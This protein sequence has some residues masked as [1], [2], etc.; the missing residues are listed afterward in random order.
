MIGVGLDIEV[1][2]A[3][4]NLPRPVREYLLYLRELAKTDPDAAAT[5]IAALW[6][7]DYECVPVPLDEFVYGAEYLGFEG[8]RLWPRLFDDLC[9]IFDTSRKPIVEVV[10]G[11]ATG[12]GKTKLGG[13]IAAR[14]LYE[15]NCLRQP[16]LFHGIS[17]TTPIALMNLSVTAQQAERAFFAEFLALIDMSPYF[18]RYMTADVQQTG[19]R[20]YDRKQIHLVCGNSQ[21]LSAI[22]LAPVFAAID[23]ANF[24]MA[25]K[26]SSR[27]VAAGELDHARVLYNH[28]KRRIK[29]RFLRSP[30]F[31]GKV[32]LLSS[33]QF[34]DDFLE[35][36]IKE[37]EGQDDVIVLQ[38][39]QWET[40]PPESMISDMWDGKSFFRVLVGGQHTRSRILDDQDPAPAPED[41]ELIA[42]P[43]LYRHDFQT[44]L[45]GAVRDVAGKATITITPFIPNREAVLASSQKMPELQHPFSAWETTLQD[46]HHLV[47]EHLCEAVSRKRTTRDRWGR[48]TEHEELIWQPKRHP[49]SPRYVHIDLAV[50]GDACG[51]AMGYS[52]GW[53]WRK[54]A[55]PVTAPWLRRQVDEQGPEKPALEEMLEIVIEFQ[56]RIVAPR[57]GEI[58]FGQVRELVYQ[59]RDLG[60]YIAKVTYDQFQSVDSRQ[61]LGSKG[62]DAE[63]LSVD[64]NDGPYQ[65]LKSAIYEDR[66]SY[67]PH[68]TFM[69]EVVKL[70]RDMKTLKIDHTPKGSKDLSDAVAGVVYSIHEAAEDGQRPAPLPAKGYLQASPPLPVPGLPNTRDVHKW[71]YG[72]E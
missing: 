30:R 23:E 28:V 4:P 25:A 56:L 62:F 47:P 37:V 59:L 1:A 54:R 8:N 35:R 68:P 60:F 69:S 14:V 20:K 36:H 7:V 9:R 57:N 53:V 48:D 3:D 12:W 31:P 41:G 58:I 44:D 10:C 63:V 51:F 42:V 52:P 72:R 15:L 38:Y 64:R 29:G 26:R 16:H 2:L 32:V 11:G 45:E 34:P 22:G 24:M 71:L 17:I 18:K 46:G 66:C 27:E 5:E 33:V 61:I 39:S 65:A 21:E 43:E 67:Y 50:S 6:N 13:T 19:Y 70:R 55:E 40:P 49:K